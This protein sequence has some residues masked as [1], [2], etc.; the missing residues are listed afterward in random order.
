[1]ITDFKHVE[2]TAAENTSDR[3]R[4]KSDLTV[5]HLALLLVLLSV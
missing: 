2:A 1:M 5:S 4:Q 3:Q